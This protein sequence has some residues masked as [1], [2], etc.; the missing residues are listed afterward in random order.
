[1]MRLSPLFDQQLE[2]AWLSGFQQGFQ[3][4]ERRNILRV[5]VRFGTIDEELA[6]TIDAILTLPP[7]EFTHL[8]M[9]L[10]RHKLIDR[11]N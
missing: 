6:G 8:L 10:S 3:Q 2:A 1:M 5:R 4:G 7:E 9:H 11:F